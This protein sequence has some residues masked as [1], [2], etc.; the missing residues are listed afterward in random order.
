MAEMS[1]TVYLA[2]YTD[3]P[4]DADTGTEISGGSYARQSITFGAPSNGTSTNSA[5]IEFPAATANWGVITHV[6]IRDALTS[7]NLL[8]HTALDA[9]KTINNGDIFKILTS[10]LSVTLA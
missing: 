4:T 7:G 3:D 1:K 9:S 8:Y 5:A 2:L 6:G 10:N